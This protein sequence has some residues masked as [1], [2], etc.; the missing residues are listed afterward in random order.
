MMCNSACSQEEINLSLILCGMVTQKKALTPGVILQAS[1][2]RAEHSSEGCVS[3]IPVCWR[4]SRPDRKEAQLNAKLPDTHTDTQ[5]AATA[6][7]LPLRTEGVVK[8]RRQHAVLFIWAGKM[9]FCSCDGS[10]KWLGSCVLEPVKRP[11]ITNC[12]GCVGSA[13]KTLSIPWKNKVPSM[14]RKI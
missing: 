2:S 7:C 9:C 6:G 10:A 11:F 3:I 12:Q 8:W 4:R 5:W 1:C 14:K 13:L